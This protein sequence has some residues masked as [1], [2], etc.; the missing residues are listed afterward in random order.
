MQVG[1]P[2]EDCDDDY[3]GKPGSSKLA[4]GLKLAAAGAE[5]VDSLGSSYI[6]L[7]NTHI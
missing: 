3:D 1:E 2:N 7:Q 4:M 5:L 6:Q